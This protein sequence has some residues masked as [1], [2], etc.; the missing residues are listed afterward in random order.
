V[1]IKSGGGER[2][3]EQ[4]RMHATCVL[5][6]WISSPGSSQMCLKGGGGG[7][8]LVLV[9]RVKVWACSEK[10]FVSLLYLVNVLS[11]KL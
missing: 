11:N 7:G 3:R 5:R 6:K 2:G 9:E 4:R 8:M 1:W 10:F